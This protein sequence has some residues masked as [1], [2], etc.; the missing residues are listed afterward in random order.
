M[1]RK[2]G[3]AIVVAVLFLIAVVMLATIYF[4]VWGRGNGQN[5][6]TGQDGDTVTTE[7]A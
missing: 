3:F 7:A 6:A 1:K 5:S 2:N 4:G